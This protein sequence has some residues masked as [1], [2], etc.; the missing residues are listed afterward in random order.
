M[1]FL[2]SVADRMLAR[3]SESYYGCFAR[4]RDNAKQT[5]VSLLL[6]VIGAGLLLFNEGSFIVDYNAYTEAKE[7]VVDVGRITRVPNDELDGRLVRVSGVALPASGIYDPTYGVGIDENF[8]EIERIV[9]TFESSTHQWTSKKNLVVAENITVGPFWLSRRFRQRIKTLPTLPA[10][11]SVDSIRDK[12]IASSVTLYENCLRDGGDYFYSGHGSPSRPKNGDTRVSFQVVEAQVISVMAKQKGNELAIYRTR[13]GGVFAGDVG[14]VE[15]GDFN[16]ASEMLERAN[17]KSTKEACQ[18]RGWTFVFL[19]V[20][21]LVWHFE[22]KHV[23][24]NFQGC[25]LLSILLG[26]GSSIGMLSV[27]WIVVELMYWPMSSVGVILVVGLCMWWSRKLLRY[28][29]Q[30]IEKRIREIQET[31]PNESRPVRTNNYDRVST[32]EAGIELRDTSEE[33][34]SEEFTDEP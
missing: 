7:V 23:K 2:V 21:F 27:V 3:N 19:S 28:Y 17:Q 22:P 12:S 25:V 32:E 33:A 16:N 18:Y 20:A 14:L 9:E 10:D 26:V 6:F 4:E 31:L 13:R 8:L 5:L 1:P 29:W 15:L 30:S 34:G 11:L 24:E